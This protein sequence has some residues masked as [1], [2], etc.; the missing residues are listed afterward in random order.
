MKGTPGASHAGQSVGALQA[1]LFPLLIKLHTPSHAT[2]KASAGSP[3]DGLLGPPST[4][5]GLLWSLK[6]TMDTHTDI[7][8]QLNNG[9]SPHLAMGFL[10]GKAPLSVHQ[11]QEDMGEVRA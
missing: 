5:Y 4:P 7:H 9:N 2:T 3:H 11:S 6:E 1:F 10:A 8:T